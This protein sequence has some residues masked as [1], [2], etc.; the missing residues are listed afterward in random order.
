MRLR[1]V[2]DVPLGAFLSGGLDSLA[3]VSFLAEA[4]GTVRTLTVRSLVHL[5]AIANGSWHWILA[6]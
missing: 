4:G 5:C 2:A 1:T 6:L 3:V